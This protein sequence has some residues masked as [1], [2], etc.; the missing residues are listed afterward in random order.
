MEIKQPFWKRTG[1]ALAAMLILIVGIGLTGTPAA[2]STRRHPS[3]PWNS[4]SWKMPP[5]S[6]LT[7]RTDSAGKGTG[8]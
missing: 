7:A 6:L 1:A 4:F 3:R 5:L 8:R 2:R